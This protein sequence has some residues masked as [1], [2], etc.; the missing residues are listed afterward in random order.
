MI[1]GYVFKE[2]ED[3]MNTSSKLSKGLKDML[4]KELL[5]SETSI[6]TLIFYD[7]KKPEGLDKWL[8]DEKANR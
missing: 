5:E 8:Q 6:A 2:K 3:N 4:H 7:P 1:L